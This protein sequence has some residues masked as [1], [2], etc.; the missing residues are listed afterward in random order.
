[1]TP[2]TGTLFDDDDDDDKVR[3]AAEHRREQTLAARFATFHAENPRVYDLLVR[4][5]RQLKARGYEHCGISL[6]WERMRWEMALNVT[7]PDGFKLNNDWRSRYARL[8][9]RQ[10]ADLAEFFRTRKLTAV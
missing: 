1:V 2:Y 4:F 5:T 7:D 8:I 3:R 6:I 9:M 10:E